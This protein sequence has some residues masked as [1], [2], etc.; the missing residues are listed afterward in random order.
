MLDP[1]ILGPSPTQDSS[2][3]CLV[4]GNKC[5]WHMTELTHKTRCVQKMTNPSKKKKRHLRFFE[6][7]LAFVSQKHLAKIHCIL[8]TLSTS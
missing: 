3:I 8:L 7:T 5:K 1:S 2:L 4:Y 6:G